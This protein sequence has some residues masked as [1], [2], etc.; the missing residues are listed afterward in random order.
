MA[1]PYRPSAAENYLGIG[2]QSVKGT[3]VAPTVFLP[4]MGAVN[5]THGM[6]GSAIREAGSGLYVTRTL[7]E[8]DDPSGGGAA[9]WRPSAI[10]KLAAWFLGGTAVSG[11]GPYTHTLTPAESTTWVSVEQN[12]EDELIE[13]FVDAFLRK[14]TISGEDAKD[15]MV[16]F[17]WA[18]L[19]KEW[20]ASATVDSYG[21][22]FDATPYK[23]DQATFTIDGVSATNLRSWS[24]ELAWVFD[25]DIRLSQVTRGDALKMRL[26][27]TVKLRQL[28]SSADDYRKVN[29][30]STSGS[31]ADDEFF[32][33]TANG[34]SAA[35][36]N[37]EAGADNRQVTIAIPQLD[38]D[39]PAEYTALNPDG[40]QAVYLE[41]SATATKGSGALVTITAINSDS[42][43]Y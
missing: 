38:Y 42:A 14:L 39:E 35:F 15:L 19:S 8:K 17:E 28:I 29:Y 3:G 25:E 32:Q 37:G 26:E 11:V 16:A 24:V 20:R 43:A 36:D 4:Y 30:G 5:L 22:G 1:G 7:K 10:D 27:A 18:S 12:L 34:F 40:T 33:V 31:A 6:A 21:T 23:Q 2:K 9:A 13:R 41:R